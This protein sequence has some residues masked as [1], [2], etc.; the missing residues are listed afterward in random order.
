MRGGMILHPKIAHAYGN[1]PN[2]DRCFGWKAV[3]RSGRLNH[4][5]A[6]KPTLACLTV[7]TPHQLRLMIWAIMSAISLRDRFMSGILGRSGLARRDTG[8]YVFKRKRAMQAPQRV[9]GA[10]LFRMRALESTMKTRGSAMFKIGLTALSAIPLT[11]ASANALDG[12]AASANAAAAFGQ[13]GLAGLAVA[14]RAPAPAGYGYPP[15]N[16]PVYTPVGPPAY[17]PVCW[18]QYVTIA[19][20]NTLVNFPNTICR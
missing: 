19:N 12:N 16:P 9:P 4:A 6:H 14:G 1:L 15:F 20:G 11:F 5:S 13:F 2:S 3:I 18:T 8:H 7:S 17:T 10:R